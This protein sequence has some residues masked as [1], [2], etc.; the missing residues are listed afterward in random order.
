VIRTIIYYPESWEKFPN[1]LYRVL[2]ALQTADEFGVALPADWRPE[3]MSL[4]L[5]AVPVV[6][7]EPDGG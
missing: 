1:E 7:Q 5:P 3:M 6:W 2:I 4:F